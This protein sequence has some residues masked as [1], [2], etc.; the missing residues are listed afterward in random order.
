MGWPQLRANNRSLQEGQPTSLEL[1]GYAILD[2]L[3]VKYEK[4][5]EI[6][7][8]FIVDARM[9]DSAV[10]IQWDGDYWHGNPDFYDELDERQEKRR[11]LDHSQDAYLRTCGYRVLRFWEHEVHDAPEEVRARIAHAAQTVTEKEIATTKSALTTRHNKPK[12]KKSDDN[13]LK[14]L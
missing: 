1:A 13:Q 4:Q 8:K 9:P 2:A 7:D 6:G 10:I 3:G 11:R 5:V 14:L 12:I